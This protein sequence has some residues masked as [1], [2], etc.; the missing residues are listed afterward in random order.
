MMAMMAS[1]ASRIQGQ[2]DGHEH[3]FYKY[4]LQYLSTLSGRHVELHDWTVTAY[5]VEFG[6]EIG[7]G[8]L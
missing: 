5:D 4:S 7:S 6:T 1:L 3:Q 2:G 8:G